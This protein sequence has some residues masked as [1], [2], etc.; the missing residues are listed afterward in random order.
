M[1]CGD[2]GSKIGA[3]THEKRVCGYANA[4]EQQE[5]VLLAGKKVSYPP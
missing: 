2:R 4:D 3:V 1:K 5:K